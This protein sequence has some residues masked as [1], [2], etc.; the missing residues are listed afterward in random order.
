MRISESKRITLNTV[1]V[2]SQ[3]GQFPPLEAWA[4]IRGS[5]QLS[6]EKPWSAPCT[7]GNFESGLAWVPGLVPVIDSLD[8][9]LGEERDAQADLY[10]VLY[11]GP[12]FLSRWA[13]LHLITISLHTGH[14]T[15]DEG[16]PFGTH[17]TSHGWFTACHSVIGTSAFVLSS[18]PA[19]HMHTHTGR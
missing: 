10:S 9:G 4:P 5:A 6:V 11:V 15:W 8:K 12:P 14:C 1:K 19:P 17:S 2:S 7:R 13:N 18:A 3:P 16:V